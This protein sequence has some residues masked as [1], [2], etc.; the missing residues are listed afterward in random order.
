M[1]ARWVGALLAFAVG[2]TPWLVPAPSVAATP[3]ITPTAFFG[4]AA[5]L[6]PGTTEVVLDCPSPGIHPGTRTAGA[7][8]LTDASGAIVSYTA[9][10]GQAGDQS[11]LEV[12]ARAESVNGRVTIA[13]PLQSTPGISGTG[14]NQIGINVAGLRAHYGA[15]IWGAPATC[16][17]RANAQP[18]PVQALDPA[19]AVSLLID[20]FK[21]VIAARI[22]PR[23]DAIGVA[24]GA[25]YSRVSHGIQ[26]TFFSLGGLAAVD[27]FRVNGPHGEM[28]RA[29]GLPNSIFFAQRT[30][31]LWKYSIDAAVIE[32]AYFPV[33]SSLDLPL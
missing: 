23:L 10:A 8:A 31:G 12:H 11:G 5:D 29:V 7:L 21:G 4:G 17:A 27:S 6:P 15:A 19:G 22:D 3:G 26:A 33:L 13:L 24:A 20:D 18:L 14:A 28:Y 2:L 1:K 25:S 30:D 9:E 32:G 16:T